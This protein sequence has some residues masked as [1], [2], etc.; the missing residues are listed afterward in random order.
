MGLGDDEGLTTPAICKH[1]PDWNLFRDG[2]PNGEMPDQ[3][4]RRA[5]RLIGNLMAMQANVAIFSH[6]HF[7]QALVARWQGLPVIDGRHFVIDPATSGILGLKPGLPDV[8]VIRLW[9][10]A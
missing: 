7:G 9:N 6:G 2:C 10:A 3:I 1:R 8:R 5:A 4:V